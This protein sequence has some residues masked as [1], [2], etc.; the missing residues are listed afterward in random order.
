MNIIVAICKKNNG[1]GKDCGIPWQIKEDMKYFKD[2]TSFKKHLVGE[3]VV[4]MG[5][6]TWES[7][8]DK[9]KPLEK[10][11][12]IIVSETLNNNSVSEFKNTYVANSLENA[13]KFCKKNEQ[14]NQNIF[15]IGGERLYKEAILHKECHYLYITEIYKEYECDT[16]FPKIELNKFSVS[17]VSKFKY[18]EKEKVYFRYLTYIN[19]SYNDRLKESVYK[20]LEEQQYIETLQKILDN[21]VENKDRTNVGTLSIF[22]E[23][24]KYNLRE[25]FPAITTKRIFMRGIFEELMLYISGK[26]D[27]K[28]LNEKKIHIWDGNTTR[29]FLD[30][31]GLNHYQEGDM[32]E[33]Y[34]FNFRHYGA[35]YKGCQYN[36]EGEGFDQIENVINLIKN[37]PTSRRILINLYN[38]ATQHKA[39]LPACL[40]QYQFYVNTKEKTLS[41]QIYLRS[42]DFFLA[43]NWNACTGAF[44][45]H[46]ICNL[47]DIDL[48]PGDLTVITGDTHIYLSHIEAV[49]ENLK[50][51]PRPPCKL[52]LKEPKDDLRDYTYSDIQLIGYHPYPSIKAE[53]A[54]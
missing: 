36:Y 29:D 15:V 24:F 37:N 40:C 26:T 25:F 32:G 17:S 4:I 38:P 20:N 54:V 50:R 18:N 12:N 49:K 8:P 42:S 19:N 23:R 44:L 48:T 45:V 30:S 46:M 13:L 51:T 10:R 27:N 11:V 43:N 41:L 6:K 47:R 31:R 1:I 39:A 14:C 7:I 5:R 52:V 22:G 34:G 3:N 53:M 2:T 16:F 9:F 35:D 21:G 28:I 33:T